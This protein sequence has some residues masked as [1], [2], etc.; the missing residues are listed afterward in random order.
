MKKVT[1]NNKAM[2]DALQAAVT[3]LG[4]GGNGSDSMSS[5]P[6][7]DPIG[8]LMSVLPKL[9]EG[10]GNQD[11]VTEKL[12]SLQKDDL[13]PIREQLKAQGEMLR[14]V[15]R[16]QKILLRELRTVRTVQSAMGGVVSNLA[17]QLDVIDEAAADEEL[18]QDLSRRR[19][20]DE[21]LPRPQ[22]SRKR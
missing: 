20:L 5:S 4:N 16:A 6:M 1:T 12:E 8:L 19:R 22:R 18:Y 7:A 15:Y 2:E 11:D 10:R 13:G 9:L 3:R 21:P 17:S 14:R